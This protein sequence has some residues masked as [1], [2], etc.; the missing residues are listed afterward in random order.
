MERLLVVVV[1]WQRS[2]SYFD[3]LDGSND[4]YVT[5]SVYI[6]NDWDNVRVGLAWMNRGNYTYDHRDDAHPIGI[7]LDLQV[8]DPNGNYVGGS[9]SWDN[10]FERVN[11]APSV[12]GYY[13]FK[14]NRYAN[15]DSGSAVRIGLYVNY[16]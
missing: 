5:R 3:G 8:Y 14:I 6:S 7:D 9:Y 12:S 2:W 4:G 1:R 16:Y 13:T 15:R 10:P 11:F